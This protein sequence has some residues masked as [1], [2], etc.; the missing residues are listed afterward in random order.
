MTLI[1]GAKCQNGVVLAA[2]RRRTSKFEKGPSVTKLFTLSC[3]VAIAGSG[4]D[5]ALNEAR[6]FIDRRISESQDRSSMATLFDVVEI[7]ASVVN[8]LVGYYKDRVEESFGYVLSGLDNLSTGCAKLYVVL[9]AGLS[10]APWVCLGS[11]SSYARPLV[12]LL[13]ANGDLPAEEA[14]KVIATIFSLVSNVQMTVGDGID[15]C[16]VKDDR[17]VD[18]VF[19]MKEVSL[20]QLKSVILEALDSKSLT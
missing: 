8:E 3:G 10:E 12:D 17:G 16:I 15:I 6:I 9:G 5:A 2:D 19:H 4:D 18:A 14:V 11:G 1:I 13:L 20:S 7:A